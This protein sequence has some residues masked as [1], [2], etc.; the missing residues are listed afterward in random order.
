VNGGPSPLPGVLLGLGLVGFYFSVS[1]LVA[2]VRKRGERFDVYE[3]GIVHRVAGAESVI[4]WPDITAV[5]PIG[6]EKDGIP[7]A[8][9]TD[10]RCELR[11]TDGRPVRFNTYTEGAVLL[12]ETIAAAVNEGTS[13]KPPRAW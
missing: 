9:G 7:H 6:R 11:L 3:R 10:F 13:P 12:A 4:P 2:A 5:R 8:M 1:R